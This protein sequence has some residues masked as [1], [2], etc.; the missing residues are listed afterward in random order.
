[1]SDDHLA[2]V[3]AETLQSY[4]ASRDEKAAALEKNGSFT[5]CYE[6]AIQSAEEMLNSPEIQAFLRQ[7]GGC[8]S[9][10]MHPTPSSQRACRSCEVYIRFHYSASEG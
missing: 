7:I 9:L 1:M 2:K 6:R 3:K 8:A 10:E 5:Q 4:R